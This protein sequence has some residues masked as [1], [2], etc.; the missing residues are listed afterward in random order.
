MNPYKKIKRLEQRIAELEAE[1]KELKYCLKDSQRIKDEYDVKCKAA[2]TKE[3]EYQK[4]LRDLEKEREH[5]KKLI[6]SMKFMIGKSKGIY[7]KAFK[8]IK[9]DLK[10]GDVS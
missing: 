5:Y 2:E 10:G 4:M 3:L 6:H 1:N 7:K 9:R 8:D